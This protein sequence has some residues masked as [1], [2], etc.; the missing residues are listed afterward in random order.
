MF[1]VF[2][3][4]KRNV[5]NYSLEELASKSD[6][7]INEL[8]QIENNLNYKPS[9]RTIYNLSQVFDVPHISL[10][11]LSGLAETNENTLEKESMRFAARAEKIERLTKEEMREL[12]EFIGILARG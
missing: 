7:D 9:M 11:R 8:V 12:E 5:L 3:K 6:I 4:G 1:S 2:V 10:L